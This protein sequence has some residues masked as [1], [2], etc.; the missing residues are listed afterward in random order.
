MCN[1]KDREMKKLKKVPIQIYLEP[2]QQ[3]VLDILSKTSGESKA[4]IIRA[5]ISKFIESLP[6]AEDPALN[7]VNLGAS[8]KKDISEQHDDYLRSYQQ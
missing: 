8:G 5:C 6:L 2:E 1:A 3:K 4:S 7:I